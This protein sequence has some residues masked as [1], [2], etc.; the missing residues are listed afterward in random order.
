MPPKHAPISG[1]TRSSIMR[2]QST[3]SSSSTVVTRSATAAAKK[4]K[5]EEE[6]A[7]FPILALP[8]ELN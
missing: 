4:R 8:T 2:D 7:Y 1:K 6:M 5:L 3:P